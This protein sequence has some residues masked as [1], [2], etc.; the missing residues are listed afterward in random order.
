MND[1]ILLQIGVFRFPYHTG[2]LIP[3]WLMVLWVCFSAWF[4]N[5]HRLNQQLPGILCLFSVGGAGSYYFAVKLNALIFL[6]PTHRALMIL[7]I[8]WF[9]LGIAYFLTVR[10]LRVLQVR[11]LKEGTGSKLK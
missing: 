3:A 8:D 4:L 10:C 11:L 7:C 9:C 2:H 5:A 1:T 6:I